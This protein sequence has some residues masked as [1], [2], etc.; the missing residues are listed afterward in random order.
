MLQT[1]LLSLDPFLPTLSG[2]E[3]AVLATCLVRVSYTPSMGWLER[4]FALSAAT[5][6]VR[7]GASVNSLGV[8]RELHS[9]GGAGE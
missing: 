7:G 9:V 5:L 8:G 6:Q 3:L 2:Y 1:L 4:F